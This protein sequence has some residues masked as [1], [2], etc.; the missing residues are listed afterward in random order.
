MIKHYINV[1]EKDS[2]YYIADS[3]YSYCIG[4]VYDEDKD[5][6]YPDNNFGYIIANNK[7]FGLSYYFYC[8]FFEQI[9]I[10]CLLLNIII[11]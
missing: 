5:N 4:F 9:Y 7:Q 8:E 1:N 11:D 3:S 2:T 10:L 6:D